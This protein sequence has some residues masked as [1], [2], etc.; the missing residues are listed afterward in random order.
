MSSR[1]VIFSP[2]S[3]RHLR[4]LEDYLADRFYPANAERYIR[5]LTKACLSLGAAPFRGTKRDDL[6]PGM[7][8]TGF[9]HRVKIF[10]KVVGDKVYIVGIF[11]G[12]REGESVLLK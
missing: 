1:Q 11:Y 10:F 6:A 4:E 8:F 2:E 5:R 9:E 12:G 3:S 7:R